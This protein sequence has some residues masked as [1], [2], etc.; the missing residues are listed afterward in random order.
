MKSGKKNKIKIRLRLLISPINQTFKEEPSSFTLEN[1]FLERYEKK[2]SLRIRDHP[3]FLISH[4]RIKKNF[5]NCQK[6]ISW[7][8]FIKAKTLN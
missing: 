5:V 1:F 6:N 7:L 3:D 2:S 8:K 4:F